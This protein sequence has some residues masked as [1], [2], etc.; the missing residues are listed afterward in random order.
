M[1]LDARLEVAAEAGGLPRPKASIQS[2][3][4]ND[5]LKYVYMYLY[6]CMHEYL[7]ICDT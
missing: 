1:A 2:E 6:I 4:L 3:F 7:Y 5:K